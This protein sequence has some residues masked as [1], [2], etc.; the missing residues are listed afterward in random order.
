M[1]LVVSFRG[2]VEEACPQPKL[3]PGL[4]VPKPLT[5]WRR[6]VGVAASW[7]SKLDA[8]RANLDPEAWARE[9]EDTELDHAGVLGRWSEFID[10]LA[11]ADERRSDRHKTSAPLFVLAIDDADMNPQRTQELLQLARWLWH[12]RVVFLLTGDTRLFLHVLESR[13]L[14][15]L[16]NS[17]PMAAT[18]DP[19]F[20][21]RSGVL[22]GELADALYDK[23]VAPGN[24]VPLSELHDVSRL[25]TV[26]PTYAGAS[27]RDTLDSEQFNIPT[28]GQPTGNVPL[29]RYFDDDPALCDALPGRLR[30]HAD[31]LVWLHAKQRTLPELLYYLVHEAVA[32]GPLGY[33]LR[34]NLLDGVSIDEAGAL[35]LKLGR[36]DVAVDSNWRTLP[37]SE[38]C[39]LMVTE[40]WEHKIRADQL[41]LPDQLRGALLLAMSAVAEMRGESTAIGGRL[42][43]VAAA[44][45]WPSVD[46]ELAFGWPLPDWPAP[47]DFAVFRTHWQSLIKRMQADFARGSVDV[48]LHGFLHSVLDVAERR[49]FGEVHALDWRELARRIVGVRDQGGGSTERQAATLAWASIDAPRL[50]APEFGASLQAAREFLAAWQ[51]ATPSVGPESF[52]AGWSAARI[53]RARA[54]LPKPSPLDDQALNARLRSALDQIALLCDF[55][56]WLTKVERQRRV[57]VSARQLLER[58]SASLPPEHKGQRPRSLAGYLFLEDQPGTNVDPPL[59]PTGQWI[60]SIDERW[61]TGLVSRYS[62]GTAGSIDAQVMTER[63]W[64]SLVDRVEPELRSPW[65]ETAVKVVDGRLRL[66]VPRGARWVARPMESIWFPIEE[67]RHLAF[68]RLADLAVEGLDLPQRLLSALMF[69]ASVAAD[70]QAT[71]RPPLPAPAKVDLC[72]CRMELPSGVWEFPWTTTEWPSPY[73]TSITIQQWNRALDSIPREVCE[74]YRERLKAWLNGLGILALDLPGYSYNRTS[75]PSLS[76]NV[77]PAWFGG[78]ASQL[79]QRVDEEGSGLR[80]QRF[81]TWA[82]GQAVALCAPESGLPR[83][84]ADQFLQAWL[85]RPDPDHPLGDDADEPRVRHRYSLKERIAEAK[86][87]RLERARGVIASAKASISPEELLAEIDGVFHNHPWS[88]L[89][90]SGAK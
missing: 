19:E 37:L 27:L 35:Q 89:L 21:H 42:R 33:A 23:L 57:P 41:V 62:Y 15:Q 63:L 84:A 40:Q 25:S 78:R 60:E 70:Q 14:A 11:A 76:A 34:R 12:R 46:P 16:S 51:E 87:A 54:N 32:Q 50:L 88:N 8:R 6:L 31:L 56:P 9:L 44:T 38:H 85:G 2:L 72:V 64:A 5:L 75:W 67:G 24:R 80:W 26:L 71:R 83:G 69:V 1:R 47:F 66:N 77:S 90:G 10:E 45:V 36:L 79:L 22:A 30:R 7:D 65:L 3:G 74:Q 59:G 81:V 55:H 49:T 39:R 68:F 58:A 86:K 73:D 48:L 29:L 53:Q 18:G 17:Q 13:F 43:P 82:V 61:L 28:A 4:S 52:G 20:S